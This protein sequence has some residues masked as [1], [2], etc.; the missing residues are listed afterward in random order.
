MT[1]SNIQYTTDACHKEGAARVLASGLLDP[2]DVF[3]A[4]VLAAFSVIPEFEVGYS[5]RQGPSYHGVDKCR[6]HCVTPQS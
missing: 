5:C 3:R 2:H 4:T 1:G 6:Y